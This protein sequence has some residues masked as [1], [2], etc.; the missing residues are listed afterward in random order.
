MRTDGLIKMSNTS[1]STECEE[2]SVLSEDVED[3]S[4]SRSS[5]FSEEE[6][7]AD[8]N[9]LEDLEVPGGAGPAMVVRGAVPYRYEP[10]EAWGNCTKDIC[11]NVARFKNPERYVMWS[12]INNNMT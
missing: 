1:S 6:L 3:S 8:G 9:D 10:A 7:R 11:E 2:N 4:D 12:H 5:S